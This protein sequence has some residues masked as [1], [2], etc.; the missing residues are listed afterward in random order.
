MKKTIFALLAIVA[1][2]VAMSYV[3]SKL[4]GKKPQGDR[5]L[6]AKFASMG[7]GIN[8]E[9][10]D[11]LLETVCEG[12]RKGTVVRVLRRS[13]GREGERDYCIEY[14]TPQALR[15]DLA[16]IRARLPKQGSSRPLPTLRTTD[17]C[18]AATADPPFNEVDACSG[19]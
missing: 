5:F 15:Q 10:L 18:A 4:R 14:A 8:K 7:A 1:G 2:A 3:A 11:V 16:R 13:W 9:A 17:A 12:A 6:E 19:G